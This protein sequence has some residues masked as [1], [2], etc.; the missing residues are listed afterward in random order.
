M[1][2]TNDDFWV[3]LGF[4]CGEVVNLPLNGPMGRMWSHMVD[5]WPEW[6]G[7][8]A[9]L[10]ALSG[11][12]SGLHTNKARIVVLTFFKYRHGHQILDLGS[13]LVNILLPIG[14]LLNL[15]LLPSTSLLQWLHILFVLKFALLVSISGLVVVHELVLPFCNEGLGHQSL[16]IREIKHTESASEVLV[17]SSK[18]SVDLPFFCGHIIKRIAGQMVELVQVLTY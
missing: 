15:S 10:G 1:K 6:S 3:L 12:M 4:I 17:Q 18:I 9:F 16:D 11:I 2:H 8:L 13:G 5:L 14:F 7:W